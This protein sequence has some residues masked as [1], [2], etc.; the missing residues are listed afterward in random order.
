MKKSHDLYKMQLSDFHLAHN[1]V[2]WACNSASSVLH[3]SKI[4]QTFTNSQGFISFPSSSLRKSRELQYLSLWLGRQTGTLFVVRLK[5]QSRSKGICLSSKNDPR[6]QHSTQLCNVCHLY[7]PWYSSRAPVSASPI[8]TSAQGK[9]WHDRNW[10]AWVCLEE[11]QCQRKSN[12]KRKGAAT[13]LTSACGWTHKLL[14]GWVL[15]L[16]SKFVQLSLIWTM[17]N[18]L[19]SFL[20]LQWSRTLCMVCV[21]KKV[22][23]QKCSITV[24]YVSSK[25]KKS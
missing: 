3:Y 7:I 2:L 22:S 21:H 24:L 18:G 11:L 13:N 9:G 23:K 15:K 10:R 6:A 12:T 8:S 14:V 5:R 25:R 17:A 4:L 20:L 1:P 19:T 16:L